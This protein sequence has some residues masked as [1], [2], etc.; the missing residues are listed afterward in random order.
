MLFQ[1]D[2]I[3]QGLCISASTN[4]AS[5][6]NPKGVL[7]SREE[8]LLLRRR[9]KRRRQIQE[10]K[11]GCKRFVGILFSHIG[12][13]GLVVAYTIIGALVFSGIEQENE[14]NV[15]RQAIFFR[16]NNTLRMMRLFF[17]ELDEWINMQDIHNNDTL[18]FFRFVKKYVERTTEEFVGI[19]VAVSHLADTD[20]VDI[21][22]TTRNCLNETL[23]ETLNLNLSRTSNETLNITFNCTQFTT[24]MPVTEPPIDP[25]LLRFLKFLQGKINFQL[26]DFTKQVVK[27]IEVDGWNGNDSMDDLKWSIAG[28]IL[29]AVTVIT[30]IANE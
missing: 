24:Q 4:V 26:Y 14:K 1:P 18:E 7:L 23:N 17:D 21:Y 22:N 25:N 9:E 11:S 15:K 16:E 6:Y 27:Q 10:L 30:T 19:P 29:Y 5:M 3:Q 2:A 20:K 12:L 13:S 28:A 8:R